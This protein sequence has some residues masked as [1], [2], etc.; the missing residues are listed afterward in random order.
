MRDSLLN[1]FPDIEEIEIPSDDF[2]HWGFTNSFY[3]RLISFTPDEIA[4][5]EQIKTTLDNANAAEYLNKT[6]EKLKAVNRKHHTSVEDEFEMLMHT[7]GF[8]I[9]QRPNYKIDIEILNIIRDAIRYSKTIECE[10]HDK[11]RNLQPL[12]IIYGEKIYLVAKE[13]NK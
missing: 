7:E 12:G 11:K 13:P 8:A 3:N 9:R 5:L 4:N 1:I 10:Y 6:I 2:K